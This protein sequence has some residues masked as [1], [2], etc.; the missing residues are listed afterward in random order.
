MYPIRLLLAALL[1]FSCSQ[2]ALAGSASP[3]LKPQATSG[4]IAVMGLVEEPKN[5]SFL[6]SYVVYS[7]DLA[8]EQQ[9]NWLYL[10]GAVGDHFFGISATESVGN[11]YGDRNSPYYG[12]RWNED[13]SLAMTLNDLE[14]ATD[15][16]LEFAYRF[17]EEVYLSG[18]YSPY[19]YTYNGN[20]V[21]KGIYHGYS[22]GYNQ[23]DWK[24]ELGPSGLTYEKLWG[25][26]ILILSDGRDITGAF[27]KYQ[28][29][30]GLVASLGTGFGYGFNPVYVATIGFLF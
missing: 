15:Y 19:R 24:V 7:N 29:D 26:F 27:V 14:N 30:W 11:P 17:S 9:T 22:V 20:E 5:I 2:I 3:N 28:P 16:S 1:L 10:H 13:L 8:Y 6:S 4:I 18:T 21:H 12:Y 25:D 23:P